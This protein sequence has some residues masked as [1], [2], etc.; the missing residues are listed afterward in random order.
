MKEAS[1]FIIRL[2]FAVVA[3]V[4]FFTLMFGTA[5]LLNMG[6]KTYVFPAADTPEWLQSCSETRSAKY[7]YEDEGLTSEEILA[8]CET[9]N[10]ESIDN[11]HR[12]KASDAVRNLSLILIALPLFLI[13]FRIV[14]RDWKNLIKK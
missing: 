5:D 1:S 13:H 2:Y 7:M 4:T 9:Y 6:L 11:Y 14:Y 10:Q 3:A 12:T 8:E